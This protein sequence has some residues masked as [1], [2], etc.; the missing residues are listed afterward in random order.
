MFTPSFALSYEDL[1][2]GDGSPH[3]ALALQGTR[4]AVLHGQLD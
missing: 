4:P 1:R 3:L 2:R